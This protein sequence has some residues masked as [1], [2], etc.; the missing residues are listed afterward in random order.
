MKRIIITSILVIAFLS[1]T[2]MNCTRH[3]EVYE[4]NLD[5]GGIPIKKSEQSTIVN[6]DE[7]Q[8]ATYARCWEQ[9]YKDKDMQKLK[10]CLGEMAGGPS[11][12]PRP[13]LNPDAVTI[14][15]PLS[16]A[17]PMYNK[18]NL[19]DHFW[20][21]K[22][23]LSKLRTVNYCDRA[24]II[25]FR[26]VLKQRFPVVFEII[27]AYGE[28]GAVILLDEGVEYS[29]YEKRG[30]MVRKSFDETHNRSTTEVIIDGNNSR[31]GFDE[32]FDNMLSFARQRGYNTDLFI[33]MN[34]DIYYT[35][36]Y[37]LLHNIALGHD[38]FIFAYPPA[39]IKC[40]PPLQ[41]TVDDFN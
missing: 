13:D 14:P 19:N 26:N 32:N 39:R 28:I 34:G 9:F 35:L 5:N 41:E 40:T 11:G 2:I 16:Y 12:Q 7:S 10:E 29:P 6:S 38:A 30:I 17:N 37:W 15:P 8:S 21:G 23:V 25:E 22:E 3:D 24:S 36:N 1:L 27:E 4:N 33:N 20:L 31:F 18:T